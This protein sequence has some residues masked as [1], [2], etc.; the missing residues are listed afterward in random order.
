MDIGVVFSFLFAY[1]FISIYRLFIRMQEK[2]LLSYK[3][4]FIDHYL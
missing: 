4:W 3:L 1:L 2:K